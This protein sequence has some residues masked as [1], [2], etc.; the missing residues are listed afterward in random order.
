MIGTPKCLR[1]QNLISHDRTKKPKYKCKAF[2]DGI[3]DVYFEHCSPF[4]TFKICNIEN[5]IKYINI[6]TGL[7][8]PPPDGYEVTTVIPEGELMT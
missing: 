4:D 8:T 1:C 7:E 3:P 5:G 2:P 6:E